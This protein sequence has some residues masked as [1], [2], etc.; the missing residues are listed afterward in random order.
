MKAPTSCTTNERG[1]TFVEAAIVLPVILLLVA[2]VFDVGSWLYSRARI[3]EATAL[4]ARQ[5]AV[6]VASYLDRNPPT[7]D[8]TKKDCYP[9]CGGVTS[10]QYNCETAIRWIQAVAESS[11]QQRLGDVSGV[12]TSLAYDVGSQP[13]PRVRV[14]VARGYTCLWCAGFLNGDL[15]SESA[16]LIEDSNLGDCPGA[17]V[18]AG[19]GDGCDP[20]REECR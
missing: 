4:A 2:M 18:S 7:L 13:Q 8:D 5:A 6:T 20:G 3:T 19:T 16:A 11:L 9:D 1:A 15:I 12:T 10:W 14:R 17:G